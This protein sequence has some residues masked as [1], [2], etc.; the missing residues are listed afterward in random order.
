MILIGENIHVISKK[1]REALINR[2]EKFVKQILNLQ[3][4]MDFT[5][6]N[7]GPARAELEGVLGWLAE[8]IEK[9]FDLKISLDTTNFSEMENAFLNIRNS[10]NTFLN[11]VGLDENKLDLMC[12][13][14]VAK[15]CNL[16]ALTM[17][18]ES[19]IPKTSDGRLDIAF[20]IYE[21]CLERG[22]N[23]E[24]IFFDPLVL[25][26]KVDQTQAIESLNTLK[27]LKES[28]EL[29][30][31]TIIG[32]SNISNGAPQH[33]RPLINRVYGV[34]AFGAGLDAVIMDAADA[35]LTRVFRMLE[36]N[37]PEKKIDSLYLKI[38]KMI[39]DF[40][41]LEEIKYDDS[42]REEV[43]IIKVCEILLNKKIYSD[44]F[45][46]V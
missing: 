20:Q 25:P 3:K 38:A 11:S 16:I 36:K 5:D 28:F 2:D 6:L 23:S 10:K 42:D 22:M 9:D 32:L 33:L 29:P 26:L 44:S 39:E 1:V 19:G 40:N 31:K 7:I 46:Q 21:K 17:G 35:E 14:A 4:N 30:A 27:M 45:A 24:K 8:I 37:S 34:M 41:E 18:K 43:E 12:K 15:S 13:L